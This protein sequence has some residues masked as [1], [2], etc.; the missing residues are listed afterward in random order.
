M[1]CSILFAFSFDFDHWYVYYRD[2]VL[3]EKDEKG[4]FGAGEEAAD[5]G[6]DLWGHGEAMAGEEDML[7]GP[8]LD[9]DQGRNVEEIYV[10]ESVEEIVDERLCFGFVCSNHTI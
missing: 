2:R 5:G 10:G 4:V 1:I 7:G 8:D 9:S 6:E 3:S